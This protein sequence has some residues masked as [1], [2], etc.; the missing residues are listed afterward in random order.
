M[1][2]P[3]AR[4]R[5]LLLA[6][7]VLLATARAQVNY[8]GGVLVQDF[9]TLP[10]SGVF[11]FSSKGPQAL[12]QTPVF[13]A[14]AAGWSLYA[15]AGTPL[16]F[17]VDLGGSTTASVYSY[18][19]PGSTERALGLL[20]N[21]TRASRAGLRLVN[22]TGQTLTQFTLSYAGEKWRTGGT[23]N[24]NQLTFGYRIQAAAFDLESGATFTA[25]PALHFTAPANGAVANALNGNVAA[26]RTLVS[27]TVTGISW[28]AGQMLVLRWQ[29]TDSTGEDDALALDDVIFFAPVATTAPQVTSV[30]PAHGATSVPTTSRL[31]VI[32]NQP[33]NLAGTW[34]QLTDAGS[35][36]VPAT[37]AGGPI[38]FEI[39]P[40]ARLQ[41]G[42]S[43]TLTLFAAQVTNGGGTPLPANVTTSF[44]T[45]PPLMNL[46]PI[47]AVQGSDVT[48]PLAGQTVTVR[49][50]VTADFQG[51]SPAM[52]GFFLQS[53]PVDEDGNPATAEGLFVYD[54]TSEG[55]AAVAVGDVVA[56][57]GLAGEFSNQTQLSYVTSLAVEGTAPLP[58]FTDA[59]LPMLTA[60]SLE[61]VEAMRVRFPQTLHVTSTSQSASFSVN[62]ARNGELILASDG[63]LVDATEIVDPNDD[64]ASGTTA[65][66][67]MNVP[68]VTAF[69]TA[70]A[71]RTLV[72]DD[73]S[74]TLFPDPTPFLNAQGTRRCG[75][76]VTGL[77]GIL[78]FS[79]GRYRI[80]PVGSVS[81]VDANPR[82]ATP[83]LVGGRVKVVAMN[84]LNY[85]TTFGGAN[86][87]GADNA[88]E[89]QRQKDKILAALVALDADVLGL[90]EIQ[91]TGAAASD[92]LA[93]LNAIVSGNPYVA[94]PDPAGGPGGDFIRTLLLYRPSKLTLFGPCYAD[95]DIVW[96][97]PNPLRLP[98]AQVFEENATGERFIACLN[99]WKSK[100][101]T[102][103]TGA[104]LD[105]LDGQGAFNDL[106]RQQ[107]ARLHAWLD[108]I[109]ATVGDNDVIVFGDLNAQGEED[110]LDVLRAA[111]YAD[112]GSRFHSADYSY[113]FTEARARL[114]HVF[115]TT[116]MAAQITFTDHWHINADE[117]A[118]L[119]YNLENKSAAHQLVNV[120]TP[121]RSSDH[122]PV[123]IG[124]N[125]APQP[126]TYAMWAAARAWPGGGSLAGDDPDHDG[127]KNLAEFLINTDPLAADAPLLP[128][129]SRTGS[130]FQLLYR[131]RTNAAGVTVHPE[132]SENLVDWL[133]LAPGAPTSLDALTNLLPAT[134]P[135]AG[136]AR[137]FGRLRIEGL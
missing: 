125:L 63:P 47:S 83:P 52:G 64:P 118:F 84:V 65:T 76:T 89:F 12:E 110:P 109:R 14:G 13:A 11:T 68:A 120:G 69:A 67:G 20:A 43:Y 100:S 101:S 59:A 62:Y 132:W 121:F 36:V 111:G 18:G 39:T 19:V 50:V 129:A 82:P 33:V 24:L 116:T 104:D 17:L 108:G 7:L 57:T 123:L 99:H 4:I 45:Q 71:L 96:N 23:A 30:L 60:A 22:G 32:F 35:T 70:N 127:V 42:A 72:L 135:I 1:F 131:Q 2:S 10:A 126:T 119:D 88:T 56:V 85:F 112:Q 87:R 124:V 49:G 34:A 98:V 29:D 55:S 86:D 79:G 28:P 113:R 6:S 134:A 48:T 5:W 3:L 122:D 103:A 106:R 38:R 114:D 16:S 93:A 46:Q 44:T 41:P 80:Q 91:N 37:I 92:L 74:G 61:P 40:A 25:V 27:A 26:N 9:D 15:N 78:S 21:S 81:F 117:P 102:G 130:H 54:L 137:M 51:V 66:G 75:D 105:Q 58:A 95:N 128:T 90:L 73:A 94:V 77:A 53:R 107:A 133:P 136:R 31:S 115:A 8:T 97:T